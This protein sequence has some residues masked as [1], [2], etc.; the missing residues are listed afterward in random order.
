MR[1]DNCVFSTTAHIQFECIMQQRVSAKANTDLDG[2]VNFEAFRRQSW[3]W[4]PPV[5]PSEAF[6]ILLGGQSARNTAWGEPSFPAFPAPGSGSTP[7][8]LTAR[9]CSA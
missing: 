2:L 4:D 1:T 9:K 8:K 3:E 5:E 6:R 7:P